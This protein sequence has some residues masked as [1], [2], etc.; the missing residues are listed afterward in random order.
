M[1]AAH[2]KLAKRSNCGAQLNAALQNAQTVGRNPIQ[3]CRMLN[4]LGAAK[5]RL[6]EAPAHCAHVIAPLKMDQKRRRN[7]L[8]HAFPLLSR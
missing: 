6:A 5:C 7:S 2:C 4:L 3:T 1:G 8:G